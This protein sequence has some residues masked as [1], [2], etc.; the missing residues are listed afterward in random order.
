MDVE[1]AE[2][3]VEGAGA[4]VFAYELDDGAPVSAFLHGAGECSTQQAGPSA[5]AARRPFGDV[6][7]NFTEFYAAALAAAAELKSPPRPGSRFAIGSPTRAAPGSAAKRLWSTELPPL[8]RPALAGGSSAQRVAAALEAARP[9]G[10]GQEGSNTTPTRHAA[11]G[12]P[13]PSGGAPP[14]L[15]AMGMPLM[16]SLGPSAAAPQGAGLF[17]VAGLGQTWGS[18]SLVAS[19]SGSNSLGGGGGSSEGCDSLQGHAGVG[20]VAGPW[21]AGGGAAVPLPTELGLEAC[22]SDVGSPSGGAGGGDEKA[23]GQAGAAARAIPP[24]PFPHLENQPRRG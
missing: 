15:L 10:S 14:Q 9:T 3:E 8:P 24:S 22:G 20:F 18:G 21:A 16:P 12:R 4:G 1:D 23:A 17:G 5:V 7:S 11:R 13:P 2:M 19:R 6:T